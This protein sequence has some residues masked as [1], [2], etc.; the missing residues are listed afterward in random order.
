MYDVVIIGGS[1]AG[2][3]TAMQLRGYRVLVIDQRPIGSH[4]AS[5]CCIPLATMRA[6]GA[7][8]A[9]LEEH[10]A[11][12][13][14]TGTWEVRFPQSA[15]YATFD[16]GR[17]CQ[18]LLAQTDAE[19][20]IAKATGYA[21]G[22]VQTTCGP[23]T[24][25]FVVDASGW[26][27]LHRRAAGPARAR[28]TLGYGIE[29]ELPER[30][31]VGPG[32]HFYF[33]RDLV[34]RGYGWVFPCGASTRIGLCTFDKEVRLAPLLEAFLARFGLEC[35]PTH[36]GVMGVD[37]R[38]PIAGELLQEGDAAGQCLPMTAEG[39]RPAVFNAIHCGQAI[40]TALAGAIS[41]AE[42][43][44]R[45]RAQA[46][47]RAGYHNRLWAMQRLVTAA[48]EWVRGMAGTV[49]SIPFLTDLMMNNYFTNTGWFGG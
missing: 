18:A 15:P 41:P 7:E 45:Y 19:V 12:V 21:D 38:D 3:T 28:A 37:R 1:F 26:Q 48:P 31:P 23:V 42:A 6:V 35:G 32:L 43:R 22:T 44:A 5:T 40:A 11:L 2:L 8:S 29:T 13:L 36:G 47:R 46:G 17:F 16:Y 27:A 10:T 14:H 34:R 4:Q 49:C 30:S 24:A 39:I 9:L 25:R 33:E 20:R